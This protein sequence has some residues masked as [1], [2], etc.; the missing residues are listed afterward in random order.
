MKWR[1]ETGRTE[2]WKSSR[3]DNIVDPWSCLATF[4][5]ELSAHAKRL[6]SRPF[7]SPDS[8]FPDDDLLIEID[9]VL[10][11]AQHVHA[12]QSVISCGRTFMGNDKDIPVAFGVRP[13]G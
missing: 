8:L 1:I 10:Q 12:E 6:P 9:P 7:S 11:P 13:D 4:L 2:S 5:A 3:V